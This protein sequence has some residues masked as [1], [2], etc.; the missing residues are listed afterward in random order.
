VPTAWYGYDE[1]TGELQGVGSTGPDVTGN[2]AA[3]YTYRTGTRQTETVAFKNDTATRLT[4]T[5][6]YAAVKA[7]SRPLLSI[8]RGRVRN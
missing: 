5:R 3:N 6:S 1:V 7:L 2:L 4:R 8:P